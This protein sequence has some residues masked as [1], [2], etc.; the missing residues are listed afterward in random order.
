MSETPALRVENLSKSYTTPSATVRALSEVSLVVP[1][2]STCAIVGPSGSGKT[3]LL[4][5]A[6][7]LDRPSAG[8]VW[9]EDQE[10]SAL[11]EDGRARLRGEKVGLVFQQYQLVPSLSA[12]ENVSLPLE[13][14]DRVPL[15]EARERARALLDQVMLSRRASHYPSQLSGGEQQRV[16]LARAFINKPRILFADEPTG[17]LDAENASR[18]LDL[19]KALTA[20]YR[21]AIV[22]VTHDPALTVGADQIIRL[23]H[24]SMVE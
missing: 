4:G 24:G 20:Q 2:G 13:M 1:A 12:L 21:T 15:A 9:I 3:T 22:L 23:S 18:A 6:A 19:M 17:N 7:G 16:A 5:L 14:E 8:S 10:I 11:D